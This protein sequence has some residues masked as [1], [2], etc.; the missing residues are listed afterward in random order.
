MIRPLIC[1][2]AGLLIALGSCQSLWAQAQTASPPA[3]ESNSELDSALEKL[4][5]KKAIAEVTR[6]RKALEKLKVDSQKEKDRFRNDLMDKFDL[7][8]AH[9]HEG[10]RLR[11]SPEPAGCE[12]AAGESGRC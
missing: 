9:R 3:Q 8:S 2:I 10:Q 11:R 4:T 7:V 6:Y 5:S 1:S 12:I